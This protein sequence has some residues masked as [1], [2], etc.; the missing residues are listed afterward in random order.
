MK[1]IRKYHVI[2]YE[3]GFALESAKRFLETILSDTSLDDSTKCRFYQDMLYRIRNHSD[4]P[5]V[6]D[7]MMSIVRE[8]YNLHSALTTVNE[9]MKDEVKREEGMEQE[10]VKKEEEEV[11]STK[12]EPT[13]EETFGEYMQHEIKPKAL[14][15]ELKDEKFLPY[16]TTVPVKKE[17]LPTKVVQDTPQPPKIA[18]T[19]SDSRN[20][21]PMHNY[22][23]FPDYRYVPYKAPMKKRRISQQT[24]NR[25]VKRKAE[26]DGPEEGRKRGKWDISSINGL[27]NENVK[28]SASARKKNKKKNGVKK[29]NGGMNP[30]KRGVEHKGE[31]Y[32][33]IKKEI[34]SE[35][36]KP[37]K[38]EIKSEDFK[39]VKSEIKYEEGKPT[40]K[41]ETFI[42]PIVRRK[43]KKY[44]K[45]QD[46]KSTS[47]REANNR[48]NIHLPQKSKKREIKDN[49]TIWQKIKKE[50]DHVTNDPERLKEEDLQRA[51]EEETV[52][53]NLKRKLVSGRVR[54]E[55]K[56][57][58]MKLEKKRRVPKKKRGVM[59]ARKRKLDSTIP[60]STSTEPPSKRRVIRGSGAAPPGSRIY[61]RLWKF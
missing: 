3:N 25:G 17:I 57:K 60:D 20:V 12:T 33:I 8:N 44:P 59:N 5:I 49:G 11:D 19:V 52:P 48:S 46:E 51:K 30:K 37:V 16:T 38:K 24:P 18:Q 55:P 32:R 40:V 39:H 23:G 61:C 28:V 50:P 43:I 13:I 45:R 21:G 31:D 15:K 58:Y 42:K 1:L 29:E 35:D 34:K 26:D 6:N 36:V 4:M 54:G 47:R 2:P 22:R 41:T 7:E 53:T 10:V 27:K 56:K 14:K 9:N